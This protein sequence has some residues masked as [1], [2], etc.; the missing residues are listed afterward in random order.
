PHT[1][2]QQPKQKNSTTT[3]ASQRSSTRGLA[4]AKKAPVSL[5]RQQNTPRVPKP[6]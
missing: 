1:I 3:R 4:M 5:D 6:F 2:A